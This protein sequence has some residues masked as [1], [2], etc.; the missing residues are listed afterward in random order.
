MTPEQRASQ[1]THSVPWTPIPTDDLRS[2]INR[3]RSCTEGIRQTRLDRMNHEYPPGH[4]ERS[5][6]PAWVLDATDART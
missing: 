6:L 4:P 2:V 5:R 3:V 1:P